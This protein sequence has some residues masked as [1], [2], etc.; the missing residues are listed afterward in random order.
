M[1]R[2]QGG[3][4]GC[5]TGLWIVASLAGCAADPE[6]SGSLEMFPLRGGRP[7]YSEPSAPRPAYF[8]MRDGQ[9][10]VH[11]LP[12]PREDPSEASDSY[13]ALCD[14][15]ARG[16]EGSTATGTLWLLGGTA[17]EPFQITSLTRATED[18]G[19]EFLRIEARSDVRRAVVTVHG[20]P[21][22]ADHDLA[23]EVNR[24]LAEHHVAAVEAPGRPGEQTA[25]ATA[26][27]G[28]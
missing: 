19:G 15:V 3:L 5:G 26:G 11:L 25:T 8:H 14:V 23:E 9:V 20:A 1:R 16:S 2:E 6:A 22:P 24:L 4:I 10:L 28:G 13:W 27:G 12:V 17:V 18:V 21:A 7:T